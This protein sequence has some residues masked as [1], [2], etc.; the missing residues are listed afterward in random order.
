MLNSI[1]VDPEA[2]PKLDKMIEYLGE[3]NIEDWDKAK[4]DQLKNEIDNWGLKYEI[5]AALYKVIVEQ[6]RKIALKEDQEDRKKRKET[7]A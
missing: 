1:D 6:Y 5:K 2:V 4:V 3:I 7:I